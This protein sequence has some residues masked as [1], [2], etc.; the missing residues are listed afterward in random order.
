VV[1]LLKNLFLHSS[2]RW[3]YRQCIPVDLRNHFGGRADIA[4]SLK[5]KNKA[6][7]KILASQLEF[8]F[9]TAFSLMRTGVV[10]EFTPALLSQII[11]KT[12]TR[13]KEEAPS[14]KKTVKLSKLFELFTEEHKP[15]WKPKTLA[16]FT[17]QMGLLKLI[18]GDID[19]KEID[20]SA[21]VRCRD[22]L[23]R[24]PPG[25]RRKKELCNLPAVELV[26]VKSDGL[27]VKTVNIHMQLLSSI[28]SSAVRYEYMQSNPAEGLSLSQTKRPEEQRS[29]FST[30][31]LQLITE[32]LPS[33]SAEKWIPLVAMFS[34][35]RLEEIAQL[36]PDNIRT[37]EGILC[38]D[39]TSVKNLKTTSASRIIPVH[40]TLLKRDF[41]GYVQSV[42]ASRN[43]WGLVAYRGGYG[44]RYGK[45]FGRWL[46]KNIT[47][48]KNKVFHSFRHSVADVLKLA[49]VQEPLV[50]Q[51]MGHANTD[52]TTGRYGSKYPVKVVQEAVEKIR[53][54]I[55]MDLR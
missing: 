27:A 5:T 11:P 2:G 13:I 25:Y 44:K 54:D 10:G 31:D 1:F 28:L 38:F 3:Y 51:I 22:M 20:R 42:P 17:A 50:K 41:A 53:Y 8:R 26:K 39:L 23:R 29:P 40:S 30:L 33:N 48:D 43:L 14:A 12:K 19:I 35:M 34:G 21:C 24:I 18:I 15:K 16:E 7:A 47:S 46:R 45:V 36:T 37:I 32:N 4:Q 9:S 49:V 55:G 6:D 52:I